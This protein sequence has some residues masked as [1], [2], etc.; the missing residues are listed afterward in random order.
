MGRVAESVIFSSNESS[1]IY[2]EEFCLNPDLE[3]NLEILVKQNEIRNNLLKFECNLALHK[4]VNGWTDE[5]LIAYGAEFEFFSEKDIKIMINFFSNH[6]W[7]PYVLAYEGE[8]LITEKF[9]NRP[10][11][12]QFRRLIA[13]QTLPSDII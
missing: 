11:P 13:N 9:G 4:Y 6:L 12:N 3:D 2:L 5:N 10:P 7:A 1:K 8:R